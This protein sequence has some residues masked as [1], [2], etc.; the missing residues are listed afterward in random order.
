MTGL[1]HWLGRTDLEKVHPATDLVPQNPRPASEKVENFDEMRA[2]LARI[3]PFRLGRVP[4][5]EPRRGP[6]VPSFLA[7][8]AGR[9]LLYQPL[10]GGPDLAGWLRAQGSVQGDFTQNS[11]RQWMRAH[12]GHRSVSV[13]RHPLHRAWSAFLAIIE[14]GNVE[15]RQVMREVHR[16]PLPPDAELAL[17]RDSDL[18]TAFHAFL[19]RN[20]AGQT[21]LAVHPGWASQTE[22]IA[23]FS[24]IRP[25]DILVRED[26]LTEDL[27]WIASM[28][29]L[30]PK[31][32]P[33]PEA[34][35]GFL[36][37]P[38]LRKAAKAAYQRDYLT[39][40]FNT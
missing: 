10:R 8:S 9:G 34:L 15:L 13:F 7:L 36:D 6:S 35:P 12:P 2:E 29:G 38:D 40:G 16:V 3:D 32:L 11:L 14:G 27:V 37:D 26:R 24:R 31:A 20:L 17:A 18:V 19:K 22:V 39:F 4:T 23:G 28:T 25:P 1:L 30:K 5:F 33:E 21:T